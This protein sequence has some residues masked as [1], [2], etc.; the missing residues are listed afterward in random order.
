MTA[1]R[2]IF[3]VAAIA[4]VVFA[5]NRVSDDESVIVQPVGIRYIDSVAVMPL[6]NRTGESSFDHIGVAIAAEISTHLARMAPLKVISHHSARAVSQQNLTPAQL[7][8]ALNVRNIIRGTIDF[9]DGDLSIDLQQFDTER[10]A[11]I[12]AETIDGSIRD[13]AALQESVAQIATEKFVDTV[14]GLTLP[15]FSEHNE[16]GPG[17]E[18]YL[19]GRRWLG[20]RTAEGLS[21]AIAE[22]ELAIELS[23]GYAPAYA[24]LSSAYALSVFYRYDIGVDAYTLAAQSLAFAEHAIALD[25]NLASGYAARGYV[26]AL[27]GRD[28]HEVEADFEKAAALQ[29]NAASIPSWRA[30]AL[31]LLGD[32]EGAIAEASRAI[33]LDPLAPAR[34]IALAELS[35]QLGRYEQAIASAKMATALEPRIIRS[36]AIEARA[37]LLHGKP[38]RCAAMSLGPHQVLR[39]TCMKVSGRSDEADAIIEETLEDS[40]NQTL[41]VDGSTE[42]VVFE[43]LAVYYALRGEVDN[44]LFWSARAYSASPAGLE[45]RVLESALFD[46]V[47]D[48][49]AFAEPIAGIRSDLYARVRR[50]S[51]EFR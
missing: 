13:L 41:R 4:V 3:I 6:E 30:R 46:K 1:A 16:A 26:G 9:D 47:R 48:D 49:P 7:G 21:K 24:D 35:L 32:Y 50:D 45:I 33:D 38:Q 43:D 39:A 34:H 51:E 5:W 11:R 18:A 29:P 19:A 20:E 25:E 8:N 36:R 27:V 17:Q 10:G 44:A 23:P 42:V 28:A 15:Q 31:A 14:P 37:L 40:R 22:F 2:I 12:W